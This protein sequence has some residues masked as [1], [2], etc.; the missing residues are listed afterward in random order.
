MSAENLVLVRGMA[1]TRATLARWNRDPWPVLRRWLVW[2]GVTACAL[3][4]AVLV[5]AGQVTPDPTPLPLTGTSGHPWSEVLHIFGR[6]LLVLAL[7]AMACVA[8]FIA[9]SSMPQLAAQKRGLDRKVHEHAGRFAILFV[10]GATL[11]SLSTQAYVLGSV[12]S[13]I[14]AQHGIAPALLI[15]GLLPHAVPELMALFLPLAAWTIASRRGEWDQL[16]AAT[17]ATTALALPTLMVTAIVEVFVS[18][19]LIL[20]LTGS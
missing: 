5:V 14:S 6:N 2:S 16:L 17:V 10:M 1:A 3:L 12:S 9:G 11:F 4:V 8:G 19:H 18:P 13:T 20:A 7:H 15:V